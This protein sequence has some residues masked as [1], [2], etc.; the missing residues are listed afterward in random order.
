MTKEKSRPKVLSVINLKGGVGKT[1]LTVA[2]AD[3]FSAEFRKKVLVVDMDP[4]TNSTLMLIGEDKWAE[5]DKKKRTLFHLFDDTL[6]NGRPPHLGDFILTSAGTVKGAEHL[7]DLVPSSIRLVGVQDQLVKMPSGDF[8]IRAPA[9]VLRDASHSAL[10]GY[11]LVLVDCPPNLGIITLNG[12]LIS[13]GYIIPTIPDFLST[14]GISQ[15]VHRIAE[16][17][18]EAGKPIVSLGIVASKRQGN[19]KVHDTTIG[20]LRKEE[21]A[22]MFA[23]VIAQANQFAGAAEMAGTPLTFK[24]K[25]GYSGLAQPFISLAKEIR[26]KLEASQ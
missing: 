17:S 9:T 23:T 21:D 6:K 11:D 19:S 25:W 8:H 12:L 22:P 3:V 7:I 20:R 16:F 2:L 1:T 14:Y 24:Q 18:R 13:D 15:I 10:D 26:Q 4:Q 5:I